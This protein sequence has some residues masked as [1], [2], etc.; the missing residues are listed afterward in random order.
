MIVGNLCVTATETAPADVFPLF[1]AALL[2]KTQPM[3][4]VWNYIHC[5]YEITSLQFLSEVTTA[6]VDFPS[7]PELF[8]EEK[9]NIESMG[10]GNP[11]GG[12]ILVV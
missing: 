8:P 10:D 12:P 2:S 3:I 7:L 6:A 5:S 4:A 11:H 1:T 9:E